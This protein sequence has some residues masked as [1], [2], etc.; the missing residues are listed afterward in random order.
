MTRPVLFEITAA[1]SHQQIVLP[2]IRLLR[3]KGIPS[4]AY[5]DCELL[6]TPSDPKT[7]EREGIPFVQFLDKPL[8]LNDF[9]WDEG[10]VPIR[11]RIPGEVKRVNPALVVVLNDRN[12]PSIV[13]VQSA[14]AL[15]IPTLLMQESL[16]KDLFQRP[17][18][19][20]LFF[21]WKH[22]VEKGIEGGL[23]KYGQGG[24]D[25]YAAWG[26]TSRQYLRRV[27]VPDRKIVITGNPRFDQ[28]A[29]PDFSKEAAAIRQ[30]LSLAPDDFLVTFLSS[31]IEKMLIVTREEKQAAIERVIDWVKA[32]RARPDG[33]RLKLGFRLHR[34]ENPDLFRALIAERGA[35]EWCQV[36][37]GPLYPIVSA[38]QA[39]LMFSTTA[40]LE[41]ALLSVPVGMVELSRPLDDWDF[42]GHGV[43]RRIATQADFDALIRDSQ[44]KP[45]LGADGRD[46]AH[47][48][49][50]HVGTAAQ[51]VASLIERL[52]AGQVDRPGQ[53]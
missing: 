12:F 17:T 35:A 45:S 51:N 44:E 27:G 28:L 34:S 19:K 6:R 25:T 16:R 8:P 37:E 3:T 14:R 20:K 26:E 39:A 40:G 22:K 52:V 7:L 29:Q 23:R 11:Q 4:I 10:A 32:A 31:P 49:L 24:C 2:V 5:T 50:D 33:G 42:T 41:A 53:G 15:R 1:D 21:R 18:L 30:Q 36:A 13:F 38:S 9:L 46:A 47:F 43:A 48:Y